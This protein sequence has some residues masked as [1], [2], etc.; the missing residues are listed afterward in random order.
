MKKHY[1]AGI[2]IRFNNDNKCFEFLIQEEYFP[3]QSRRMVKFPGG[4]ES[5]EDNSA[6]DN[7]SRELK[8]E[9]ISSKASFSFEESVKSALSLEGNPFY[10]VYDTHNDIEKDYYIVLE[11]ELTSFRGIPLRENPRVDG[12]TI[13]GDIRWEKLTMF[14]PDLLP[15]HHYQAYSV[16][17]SYFINNNIDFSR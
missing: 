14:Y 2:L 13:L 12:D 3:E 9:L 10:T 11:T 4:M 8:D 17:N 6:E 15:K 16:L 7:L 5:V 1:R